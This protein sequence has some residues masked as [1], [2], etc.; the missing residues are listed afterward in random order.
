MDQSAKALENIKYVV[1]DFDG[2][3][4]NTIE[5]IKE[6][7]E[8]EVGA[9]S[10]E[11]FELMR[12]EGVK[13]II[14]RYNLKPWELPKVIARFSIKLKKRSDVNLYPDIEKLIN[15]LSDS[16]KLGIL[17][18]NSEENIKQTLNRYNIT[19]KFDFIYS[20]SSLFGKD[21]VMRKMCKKHQ[22]K[23]SQILYVGDEDRD[24]AA[25]KKVGIRSVAVTYG[26]NDKERLLKTKP[27]FIVDS[28][29]EILRRV[30]QKT[31]T[32]NPSE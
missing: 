12:S 6:I 24:I 23:T 32:S 5:V 26:F 10:D 3:L 19:D 15:A 30:L 7:A 4:A 9:I 28:P 17:S 11:D 2:T 20:Q 22:I 29:M 14:K 21:K 1:F 25:C 31:I 13:G 18:S 8:E 27:D 16:Y